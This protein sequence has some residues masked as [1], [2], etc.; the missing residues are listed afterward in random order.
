MLSDEVQWVLRNARLHAADPALRSAA[1]FAQGAGRAAPVHRAQV[2]RWENGGVE[3]TRALV[4]RYESVLELPEGQLLAAVDFFARSR[5]PVRPAAAL[6]PRTDPDVDATLA[7]LE[8]ALGDERMSG[9]DWD[10]LSDSLGR[11][12]HVLVRTSDWERL[13]RRLLQELGLGLQLDYA[14]RAEA[15]ARLAGHPR[16][17]AVVARLA[18]E[19]VARPDAQF[20]NDTL[21]LLQFTRDPEALS[22]LFDQLRA[23]TNASS[24][25]ACLIVLTT[26]VR[27]ARL[28]PETR[29]EA[30]RLAVQHLRDPDQPYLVHRGAANLVRTLGPAGSHRVAAVLT[31]ED[32]RVAASIIR[33]GRAITSQAIREAHQRIRAVLEAGE[34]RAA[35]GEPVLGGLLQT[36]LGETNEEDRSNALCILMLSPQASII[37]TVHASAF[38]DAMARGD[39]VA[40]HESAT[41]LTWMG[42]LEDLDLFER[43]A[44]SPATPPTVA[45]EAGYVVGNVVEPPGRRRDEREAS[46]ARRVAEV[47]A[48]GAGDP[49]AELLRG[50]VYVLGMRRRRDLLT[51]L[52]DALPEPG[53]DPR[54]M[55]EIARGVLGWWLAVPEH[56]HPER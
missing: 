5:H 27:G 33:D 12:P 54:A 10:R 3:V 34:G 21:S 53:P 6:P 15:L 26:L 25:R 2:G 9:L 42:Q 47:I 49:H 50:L 55:P 30:I 16:S 41:V 29:L 19:V 32:R 1:G 18:A 51:A 40:A 48:T 43:V 44:L 13:F 20:Y 52:A 35:A 14:Q 4:R 36:A 56:L 46:F 23:P 8:R 22:V 28:E 38:A 39:H 37:G 24:L 11:M 31:A 45:M 17:G 7:L